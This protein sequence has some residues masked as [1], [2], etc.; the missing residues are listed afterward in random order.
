MR[1]ARSCSWKIVLTCLAVIGGCGKG[2][3]PPET[4]QPTPK[5]SNTVTAEAWKGQQVGRIEELFVGRFA[6]VNVYRIDGGIQVVIR[7]QTSVNSDTQPLY[8]I[9]GMTIEAGPGGAL[10][11]LNPADI[12]SIEVLKDIG[13]TSLY[14]VRG[15]NGVIV[16]KTKQGK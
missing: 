9:D 13:S 4:Q 1:T 14:G 5:P 11:G 10:M 3:L 12:E 15:A 2:T 8:V 16:I 7:G 6:G